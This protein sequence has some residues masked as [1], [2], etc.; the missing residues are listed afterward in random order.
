MLG[1]VTGL[2]VQLFQ[3]NPAVAAIV[4]IGFVFIAYKL[5]QFAV[6]VIFAGAVFA[7][8][9]LA[10]NYLGFAV[11]VTLSSI[12]WFALAGVIV[13]FVL[14]AIKTMYKIFRI[15]LSPFSGAWGEKKKVIIKV[16][17][18]GE[19]RKGRG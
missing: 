11:P 19:K 16:I 5:F 2:I 18:E 15:V 3:L 10:L 14:S 13:F 9:P 7:F 12:L 8:F 4:L 17:K 1:E 6:K